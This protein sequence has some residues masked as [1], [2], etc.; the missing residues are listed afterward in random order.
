MDVSIIIVNWNTRELLRDC[1]T[2]VFEQAG[3]VD[4]E[5]IVVDNASTDGS[6]EMVRNEFDRRKHP[7]RPANGKVNIV[8]CPE[9]LK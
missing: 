5:V 1:L 6:V 7:F 4:Y 3:D 8:C 2:S 9:F